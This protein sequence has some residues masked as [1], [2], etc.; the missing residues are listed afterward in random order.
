MYLIPKE[1][2]SKVK[3][4]KHLYLKEFFLFVGGMGLVF[5]LVSLVYTSFILAYYIFSALVI[6]FLLAPARY[7]PK[8]DNYQAIYYAFTRNRN[9]LHSISI[10]EIKKKQ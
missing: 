3:I 4:T 5:S 1:L 2:N 9:V 6:I 7:N 10:V 8:R